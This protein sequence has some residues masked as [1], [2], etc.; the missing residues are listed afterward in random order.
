MFSLLLV[1]LLLA[2]DALPA[3]QPT[4]P[5]QQRVLGHCYRHED[6]M[7]GNGKIWEVFHCPESGAMVLWPIRDLPKENEPEGS[8]K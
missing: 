2:T 6:T 8:S 3:P 4:P 1:P 7:V 5:T